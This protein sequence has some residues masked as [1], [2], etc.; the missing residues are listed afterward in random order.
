[1]ELEGWRFSS[2]LGL[3]FCGIKYI[4]IF[5]QLSPPPIFRTFLSSPTKTLNLLTPALQTA[6]LPALGSSCSTSVSMNATTLG[7]S[8]KWGD[9]IFAPLWRASFTQHN[10]FKCHHA[11][12]YVRISFLFK[13]ELYPIVCMYHLSLLIYPSVDSW[14]VSS[15]GLLWTKLLW[16]NNLVHVWGAIFIQSAWACT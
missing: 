6:T 2:F 3:W 15:L 1:M 13:A 12:A 7:T 10:V 14:I 5:V 16:I 11:V 8:W 4:Y 9:T